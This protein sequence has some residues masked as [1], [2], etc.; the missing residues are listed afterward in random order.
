MAASDYNHNDDPVIASHFRS[1]SPLISVSERAGIPNDVLERSRAYPE[2]SWPYHR[3]KRTIN[4]YLP[5]ELLRYIFLFSIEV[6]QMKSGRLASVCRHWRDVITS[7]ASLWST[8]NVGTWTEREQ[9]TT[10]LQRAYPKKVVIDTQIAAQESSNTQPLTALQ[11][12]IAS[13]R[14]WNELTIFSFPPEDLASSLGFPVASPLNGLKVLHIA[15]GCAHS[16]SFNHLFDLVPTDAPL[17]ELRLHAAFAI[18]NFLQ[19]QW[20]PALQD[21]T[22]LSINGQGLHED[23]KSVV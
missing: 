19:P 18:T 13:T 3:S 20:L 5:L 2:I 11:D 15:A 22:V 16:P 9:V 10:W 4:T 17:S 1:H 8:L 7:I 14:E 23:R 6:H 21:L 12:A